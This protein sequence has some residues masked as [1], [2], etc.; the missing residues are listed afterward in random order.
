MAFNPAS[1]LLGVRGGQAANPFNILSNSIQNGANAGN[2]LMHLLYGPQAYQDTHNAAVADLA[3]QNIKNQYMPQS[4]QAQNKLLTF[5]ANNPGLSLPGLA[6][7]LA[8]ANY[9]DTHHPQTPT[10]QGN[11]INVQPDS[12]QQAPGAN[13]LP[14]QANSGLQQLNPVNANP[15]QQQQTQ[16]KPQVQPTFQPKQSVGDYVDAF[17]KNA[18]KGMYPGSSLPELNNASP[19]MQAVYN[20]ARS[21]L[22]QV[23]YGQ[24][25]QRMAMWRY[26]PA[27]EKTNMMAIAAGYGIPY[28]K[29]AQFFLNGGSLDDLAKQ[30]GIPLSQVNPIYPSD[31]S[32]IRQIQMRGMALKAV[33]SLTDTITKWAGPYAPRIGTISPKLLWQQIKNRDPDSQAKLMA[34]N[35]LSP[36]LISARI[37]VAQGQPGQKLIDEM[38]GSALSKFSPSKAFLTPEVFSKAQEY[39]KQAIQQ[40]YAAE[41]AGIV[42]PYSKQNA[43]NASQSKNS[44]PVQSYK[45]YSAA[46]INDYA[47]RSGLTPQEVKR[48]L[49]VAIGGQR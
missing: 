21:K 9:W 36:E 17:N 48:K 4:L 5:K 26:M 32:A 19:L 43:V 14:V 34:A 20:S 35:M 18:K 25:S 45:G 30:S 37:R 16:Q 6:G 38:Q 15:V 49:S 11:T 29:S 44:G 47:K 7:Q 1:Y 39:A 31:K 12:V 33:D 3:A 23:G 13:T 10:P 42:N 22:N 27:N 41:K 2:A 28:G 8:A 46:E 40:A 24:A